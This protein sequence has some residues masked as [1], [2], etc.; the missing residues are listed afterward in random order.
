MKILKNPY[1]WFSLIFILGIF[2][3][4][5]QF[6]NTPPG[7]NQ[8]EAAAGYEAY[9]ILMTGKDKWGNPLPV[10]FPAWG[11]GQNAL[12]IYTMIPS[13]ALFGLNTFAVRFPSLILGI[14]TLPIVF[15][16]VRKLYGNR[17]ALIASGL[18][19]ILPWHVM[20]SRWSLE[21]NIL[22][23][24]FSLGLLLLTYSL[25]W[26]EN[27]ALFKKLIILISLIPFALCF[28]SYSLTLF[29]VPIF[30]I[31][32]FW[33]NRKIFFQNKKLWLASFSLFLLFSIPMGLFILQNNILKTYLGIPF[34]PLFPSSRISQITEVP[35]IQMLSTNIWFV[36]TGFN[37]FLPWNVAQY[38]LPLSPFIYVFLVIGIV[39]NLI[40]LKRGE[41]NPVFATL[42]AYII[43][44]F[45]VPI[46][47]NRFNVG[48]LVIILLSSEGIIILV[49][50]LN[51]SLKLEA[52]KK[53]IL[54]L[55]FSLLFFVYSLSFVNY[56]FG[57]YKDSAKGAFNY[58]LDSAIEYA[59]EKS[60]GHEK[61]YLS[62][63]APINY[64]YYDFLAGVDP[65]DFQ[66]NAKVEIIDGSYQVNSFYNFYFVKKS[67]LDSLEENEKFLAILKRDES[68]ICNTQKTYIYD[69]GIW[70]IQECSLDQ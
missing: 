25:S 5:Y 70:R 67:I 60:I 18:L 20:M 21:S 2:L 55:L 63:Y 13:I 65:S 45:L 57:N 1:F 54:P 19:T 27:L 10:Y 33:F 6:P 30:L 68:D 3:R 39:I 58:N 44:F 7:I 26:K 50:S 62:T 4:I 59:K 43:P 12:L 34:V 9:S 38:Y 29:V 51:T 53:F 61:I 22:P 42:L 37:D 15:L 16:L 40:R 31:L 11:S 41:L 35:Y 24:I 64:V 52:W 8:D 47:V 17:T 66:K 56:Y 49:N 32:I 36:F 23:F 69:D 14:L 46:N 48:L 28:Y